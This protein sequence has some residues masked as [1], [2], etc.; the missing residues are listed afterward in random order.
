MVK[1]QSGK[2]NI[3][4][5]EWKAEDAPDLMA[6]INNIKVLENLRDG[7]PYP[8]TNE[9]AAEFI[10]ATLSAE[11]D[12]QYAFAICLDDKVI[13]SIGVFRK[14]NVHRYTA[15]MG[16]YIAEPYW[17]KGIMT[18]AVRQMSAYIF[19]NTD[20]TRIF[21][22]PY[23]HNNASCRVLEKAGFQFEGVLR[24]NAVKNGQA[25]DMRMYAI[26]EDSNE[27]MFQDIKLRIA[28]PEVGVIIS[29]AAMDGSPEGVAKETKMYLSSDNL[30]F[31]GWVEDGRVVGICGF[32]VH[33]DKVDIQLI[34]VAEDRQKQGIGGAMVA[35]LQKLYG[36]P[37]RAET[38]EEAVGFYRKLGFI[39]TAFQHPEW[40][41]KYTCVLKLTGGFTAE[42][43]T[44]AHRSL[45][46]TIN[47]CEKI[48]GSDKLP[49]AQRT[50]TERRISALKIA[51]EL[52]E[53]EQNQ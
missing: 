28:E 23:T 42:E 45:S 2:P 11:K 1:N 7:I 48:L 49:Q 39:T 50:L 40:G 21:A 20:I 6:A 52:I 38:V 8:Y 16:Y 44:E 17:G 19:A 35:A 5:R 29:Y 14:D 18:K 47:K 43:L 31:Y 37:L 24:K 22:E 27:P 51:L 36:L 25:V 3:C 15:E 34:S 33:Y 46:S 26:V 12:S 4:L 9:D 32:E 53:K 30:K 13:G 10:T 41:E